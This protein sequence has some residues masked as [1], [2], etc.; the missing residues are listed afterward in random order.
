MDSANP[1]GYDYGS[2]ARSAVAWQDFEDLKRLVGFTER[3]QQLLHKAG[4]LIG[5]RFEEL[6]GH[7][8]G[9]IGPWVHATFAGPD[10]ERYGAVA[11]ARFGR[12]IVDSFVRQYDQE[13]LDYQHEIGLRHHRARKNQTDHV[14]SVPVV[15]LR[16][17]VASVQVLSVIPDSFLEGATTDDIAGMRSAWSRSLLLQIALWTRAY[18]REDDW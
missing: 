2:V 7:W 8:F 6:I 5:P 14:S 11:G 16:H 17:L 9:Q 4:D 15:P 10:A 1:T 3:D 18:V 13:W 12:G